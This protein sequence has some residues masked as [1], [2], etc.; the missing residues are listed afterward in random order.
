MTDPT[1]DLGVLAA[2]RRF[3]ADLRY[4]QL[5][6]LTAVLF[7][8]DLAIPDLVPFADEILLGLL[9]LLLS[10]LRERHDGGGDRKVKN[11]T[12]ER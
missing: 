7:A 4:P 6:V 2:L 10:R 5:F 9:T 1:G 3:A 12:P 11:V 8:L